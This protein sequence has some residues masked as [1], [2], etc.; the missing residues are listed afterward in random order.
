MLMKSLLSI[1]YYSRALSMYVSRSHDIPVGFAFGDGEA[2]LKTKYY[3]LC[4]LPLASYEGVRS[5]AG[6]GT[7]NGL[8]YIASVLRWAAGPRLRL[9]TARSSHAA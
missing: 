2:S 6:N 5:Y 9:V 4:V 8:A 1:G 3:A 7:V